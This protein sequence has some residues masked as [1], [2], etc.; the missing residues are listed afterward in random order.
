MLFQDPEARY[1]G[2]PVPFLADLFAI[3]E[4]FDPWQSVAF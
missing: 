3:V 1:F 4:S 2:I